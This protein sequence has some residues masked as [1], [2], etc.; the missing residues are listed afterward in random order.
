M[1]NLLTLIDSCHEHLDVAGWE[2][3][4]RLLL[5]ETLNESAFNDEARRLI[6]SEASLCI[7]IDLEELLMDSMERLVFDLVRSGHLSAIKESSECCSGNAIENRDAICVSNC[8]L[9][10]CVLSILLELDLEAFRAIDK[11]TVTCSHFDWNDATVTFEHECEVLT[12]RA[13]I[14][15]DL[16]WL[17]ES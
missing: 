6:E 2:I 14:D 8:G 7:V 15:T 4:T 10:I 5:D 16:F 3:I 17:K 11:A 9:I 12:G 13:G 1:V